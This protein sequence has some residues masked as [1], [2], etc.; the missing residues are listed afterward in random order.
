MRIR[1]DGKFAD[2]KDEIGAAAE[3]W[4]CNNTEALLR[5]AEFV[6]WIEPAIQDVLARD[7]LTARQKREIA[8]TLS[9]GS[10]S[11]SVEEELVVEK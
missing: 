7:D 9:V 6:R 11:F 5:S 2:R 3:W 10:L 4:G 1:T 8:E